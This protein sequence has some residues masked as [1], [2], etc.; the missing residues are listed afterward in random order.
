MVGAGLEEVETAREWEEWRHANI[1]YVY[2]L[3]SPVL[4]FTLLLGI[5][6][7]SLFV[8]LIPFEPDEE[9]NISVILLEMD[10]IIAS[11]RG[12]TVVVVVVTFEGWQMLPGTV[13]GD[14]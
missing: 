13:V 10:V 2:I 1:I 6:G 7:C 4:S 9:F 14:N 11:V 3:A 12:G 8:R 5:V